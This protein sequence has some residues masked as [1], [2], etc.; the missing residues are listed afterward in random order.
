MSELN[1][2]PIKSAAGI[3]LQTAEVEWKGLRAD[4]RWMLVNEHNR[5]ITQRQIPKM[6]LIAIALEPD[7]LFI[8]APGMEPLVVPYSVSGIELEVEVWGDRCRAIVAGEPAKAWFSQFLDISCQLV[9]LPDDSV[10]LVD[11][12]YAIDHSRD[13]VSFADAFP[14]LLISEASLQDLNSRLTTPVAMNRF[15][16]NLV[17]KGCDPF[18][19]DQWRK[20]RI[21]SVLLHVV[22]PCS[23][24]IVTT[25]EQTT[26]VR[27][28]EPLQTLATYRLQQGQVMFGQNLLHANLGSLSVGDE[29]EILD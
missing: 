27:G 4:R 28:Q 2:Y 6:A 16:P 12:N 22:K 1:I 3:S 18:A 5:F 17:V 14:F 20:I 25:V 21:G 15:R 19:E 29:V 13:Q 24:C 9:Y 8:T 10:R 23:R 7:H 26:G 11:P